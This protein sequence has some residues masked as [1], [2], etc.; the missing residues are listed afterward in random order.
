MSEPTLTFSCFRLTRSRL[1]A[2]A[3]TLKPITENNLRIIDD[4]DD[5]EDDEEDDDPRAGAAVA[6][7]ATHASS[8]S[9]NMKPDVGFRFGGI[10][11]RSARLAE[12]REYEIAFFEAREEDD[13]QNC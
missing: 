11:A 7:S 10:Q 2:A 5:D 13:S 9:L 8:A 1:S 4:D 3:P 6:P 12:E